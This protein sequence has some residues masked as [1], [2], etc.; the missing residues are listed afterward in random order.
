RWSSSPR[1]RSPRARRGSGARA[2]R[3]TKASCA[4]GCSFL[5][6]SADPAS[7]QRHRPARWE[8]AVVLGVLPG[9]LLH[10]GHVVRADA[11]LLAMDDADAL[12][13]HAGSDPMDDVPRTFVPA[14]GGIG[15]ARVVGRV[16]LARIARTQALAPASAPAAI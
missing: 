3:A 11:H 2:E 8:R 10:A 14:A 15:A 7:E 1:S 6:A 9:A 16:V 4:G 13:A 5:L 12:V